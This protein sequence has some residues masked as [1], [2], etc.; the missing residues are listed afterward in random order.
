MRNRKAI[1][2]AG[3]L[4][5]R[6]F[7]MTNVISK[8]LL[9]VYDKPMIYYPLSTV[10]LADIRDILFI[11]DQHTL[12]LLRRLFDNGKHLGLNISYA[13]QEK[14]NGIAE[15]FIIGKDFIGN[16]DV[17][18]ILGD[19]IFYGNG[20][21]EILRKANNNDSATVFCCYVK[22]PER[23]GI[24]EFDKNKKPLSIEEKPL[25]PKSNYAVTG[26]YFYP[27]SVVKYSENLQPSNRGEL[28]ITDINKIYLENNQLSVQKLGRGFTWLDTGTPES[29][30][31]ASLIVKTMQEKNDLKISCIEEIAFIKNFITEKQF[32]DIILNYKNCEY[33]K[34]LSKVI[35]K[36]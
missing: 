28:E 6:L 17:C 15:S 23:F 32:C 26:L 29:L 27:N 2:L 1:I 3:G 25:N 7:P 30:F 14:P 11:S 22:T 4:G 13:V 36:K 24:I 12:T 9:P 21:S 20:F 35:E 31:N 33:G 5:T 18:L 10:M 16:D 19:N 8:Q 34:Y